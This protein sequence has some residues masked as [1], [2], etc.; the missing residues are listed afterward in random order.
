MARETMS[1]GAAALAVSA[2]MA[3]LDAMLH[4]LAR[5]ANSLEE[6]PEYD[7]T[8]VAG[9][10]PGAATVI[11]V[12]I[13]RTLRH[14]ELTLSV[15]TSIEVA[16]LPGNLS[17]TQAQGQHGHNAGVTG[18]SNASV[19]SAGGSVTARDYLD[20]SGYL[21]VYFTAAGTG[22]A[23]LRVR[24]LDKTQSRSLRT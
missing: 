11:I 22:Y 9:G 16:V 13:P 2:A 17:I 18:L 1:N 15:T 8:F 14:V 7:S 19:T 6:E 5:I 10:N 20:G 24:S 12:Q 4:W 21:S 23:N 3:K